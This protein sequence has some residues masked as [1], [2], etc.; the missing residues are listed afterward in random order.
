[1][2]DRH[3]LSSL[4]KLDAGDPEEILL[5]SRDG[6]DLLV[7]TFADVRRWAPPLLAVE[8]NEALLISLIVCH[9]C[10]EK[11]FVDLTQQAESSSSGSTSSQ[12]AVNSMYCGWSIVDEAIILRV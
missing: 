6:K 10:L 8:W 5:S 11:S 3:V 7:V 2:Y 4:N 9:R 1:M 12:N